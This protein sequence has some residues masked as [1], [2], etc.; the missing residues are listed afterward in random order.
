M[1][2]YS[3]KS[4]DTQAQSWRSFYASEAGLE[5]VAW[6]FNKNNYQAAAC[7]ENVLFGFLPNSASYTINCTSTPSYQGVL[8]KAIYKNKVREE[9]IK[10]LDVFLSHFDG[11]GGGATFE[12]SSLFPKLVEN[13]GSVYNSTTAKFGTASAAFN[14]VGDYLILNSDNDFIFGQEDFT[15]ELWAQSSEVTNKA[16]VLFGNSSPTYQS[17]DY[18]LAFFNYGQ[19]CLFLAAYSTT[20]PFICSSSTYMDGNWHH[21]ALVR[22]GS[23]FT[24][25]VDG[26]NVASGSNSANVG[27]ST[28]LYL[29]CDQYCVANSLTRYLNGLIDE[30]RVTKG[31]AR[32]TGT[33]STSTEAYSPKIYRYLKQL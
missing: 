13:Y 6:E 32:Y 10:N 18:M 4:S 17:G 11:S 24:I 2:F 9:T 21:I 3:I 22:Q 23:N 27:Y 26:Q 12:D 30:L 5:R 7:N 25:Y 1:V 16:R 8:S 15:I 14:G 20:T 33:F 31:W 29:G 19:V 28:D